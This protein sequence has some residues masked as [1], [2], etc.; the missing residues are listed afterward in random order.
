MSN[1]CRPRAD[2][3]R[4]RHQGRKAKRARHGSED[5]KE[6]K[7]LRRTQAAAAGRG[8]THAGLAP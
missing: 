7:K 8:E 6:K 2:H 3:R 4:A 1:L 5:M